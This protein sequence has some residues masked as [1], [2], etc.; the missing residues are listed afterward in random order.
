MGGGHNPW[1]GTG[2]WIVSADY[3]KQPH[4]FEAIPSIPWDVVVVDEAHDACGDSVRHEAINEMAGRARH[5]LLLTATPHVGDAARFRRLEQLGRLAGISDPLVTFRRTK[6]LLGLGHPRHIRWSPVQ[7]TLA[8]SA[9]LDVVS[10]FEKT[11]L[12]AVP[13]ERREG[14]LLLLSVLRKRALSTMTALQT[15][16]ERR[17]KWLSG[18][19]EDRIDWIQPRLG[20]AD[21]DDGRA[22][23]DCEGLTVESGLSGGVERAWLRRLR[24]LT[25]VATRHETKVRRVVGLLRRTREPVVVF[26]EFRHSLEALK[27]A[28][29]RTLTRERSFAVLHGGQSPTE[30]ATAIESFQRGDVSVLLTTDVASQGLNLQHRA[31]WMISLELPWTPTRIEQRLGRVDRIGQ[32]RLVHAT[33]LVAAHAAEQGLLASLARR[34]LAVQVVV[35]ADALSGLEPPSERAVAHKLLTGHDRVTDTP[36]DVQH[37]LMPTMH[38]RLAARAAARQLLLKR[39]LTRRWRAPL[40]GAGRPCFT[41]L[42]T[43]GPGSGVRTIVVSVPIVDGTGLLVERRLLCLGLRD[44]G[45]ADVTTLVNS[46]AF[47]LWIASLLARRLATLQ[48]RAIATTATRTAVDEAIARRLIAIS[49]PAELQGGLFDRHGE[50]AFMAARDDA[51]AIERRTLIHSREQQLSSALDVAMPSLE[52]VVS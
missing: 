47:H 6:G 44:L 3:L 25:T 24:A 36:S 34:A 42:R 49:W 23:D 22:D 5:V 28:I 26:T 4:V 2:V 29:E 27:G 40:D 46:K 1:A 37:T 31:R 32:T 19:S 18:R 10:A 33:L 30:R 8:E 38:W 17:L 11:M 15:S 41:V 9:V 21:G 12:E 51:L 7:P 43:R 14:A 16:V 50:R 45:L 35:G 13:E 48:R 52:L 20:F 39:S